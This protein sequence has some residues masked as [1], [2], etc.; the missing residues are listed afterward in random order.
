MKLLH[1]SDL[2]FGISIANV[3]MIEDQRAML[4]EIIRIAGEE[5][6]DSVLIAGDVFDHALSSAQ[7]IALYDDLVTRLCADMGKTVALCAGNHDGAARLSSCGRLLSGAG[8][9]VAGN[10]SQA[11][12]PVR[13]GDCDIH[14]LPWFNTDEV[15]YLYPESEVGGYAAA[16]ALLLDKLRESFVPG[17]KNILLAHCF[18]TG[19]QVV[20][21]DR[22][23][24]IGGANMVSASA[25]EGF[26][27]VALGHLHRAQTIGENVR[28]SGSPLKYSFDE[29]GR[30]KSVTI[31]DTETGELREREI[32]PLHD[33]RI[34]KGSYEQ[35]LAEAEADER[36]EDY[37][38]AV[39]EDEYA[40][41]QLREALEQ[42]YPNML[43]LEGKAYSE[44][45]A[46]TTL[47]V[48]EVAELSAVDIMRRFYTEST[49][50]QSPDADMEKWFAAAL[51]EAQ[52]GE[53]RQ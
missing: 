46:E 8:L 31:Y 27:Y 44:G 2:H 29:T 3:S 28:Y 45:G 14:I 22:S 4:E 18:V 16:F 10:I 43:I 51:R 24:A 40:H 25:F 26:D 30:K 53:G 37:I 1:T 17:H 6:V 13:M 20:E 34:V 11:V 41:Q 33:M 42:Y 9:H 12:G 35:V 7:A 36:R 5:G 23:V 52:E 38:K 32:A 47:T 19:A 39:L 50:G 48:G 21:S 15:R 49:D